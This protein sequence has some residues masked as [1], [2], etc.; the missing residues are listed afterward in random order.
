MPFLHRAPA[1]LRLGASGLES[2]IQ[3]RA[4]S[5]DS[6]GLL[7]LPMRP[8]H[9]ESI[10]RPRVRWGSYGYWGAS[11]FPFS[12][13]LKHVVGGSSGQ[14]HNCQGWVFLGG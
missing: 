8:T 7:L 1:S 4:D 5:C 2:Q 9:P 14:R 6:W 13:A 10:N 11:Q 3:I 12:E